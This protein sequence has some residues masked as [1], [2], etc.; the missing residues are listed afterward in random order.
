MHCQFE[1]HCT[2]STLL[3]SLCQLFA[4][5]KNKSKQGLRKISERQGRGSKC[6]SA[7]PVSE[8]AHVFTLWNGSGLQHRAITERYLIA[9]HQ[10]RAQ[11]QKRAAA[12]FVS[13]SMT[14]HQNKILGI[15]FIL[16]HNDARHQTILLRFSRCHPIIALD[17]GSD[18]SKG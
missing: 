8:F 10:T 12:L 18:F 5:H 6:A 4:C 15:Q 9:L 13:R 14:S 2:R 11:K 17:V 1:S 7:R 16:L 3:Q